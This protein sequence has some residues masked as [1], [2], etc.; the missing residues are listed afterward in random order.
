MPEEGKVSVAKAW[1]LT[2][3]MTQK[4]RVWAWEGVSPPGTR[5]GDPRISF[6][7]AGRKS[8]DRLYTRGFPGD[9]SPPGTDRWNPVAMCR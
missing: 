5:H 6:C 4:Q 8:G 3:W 9:P 7:P 1:G 2:A